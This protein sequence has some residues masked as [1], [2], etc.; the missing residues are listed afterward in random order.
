MLKPLGQLP[1]MIK[2]IQH[3]V[4]STITLISYTGTGPGPDSWLAQLSTSPLT[5]I[6]LQSFMSA[7]DLALIEL[8]LL[9]FKA[10]S[11]RCWR[12]LF[13]IVYSS[14]ALHCDLWAR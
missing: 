7:G 14:L 12:D 1:L 5:C 2:V 4:L 10:L 3:L 9:I 6:D 8:L 13:R 11:F